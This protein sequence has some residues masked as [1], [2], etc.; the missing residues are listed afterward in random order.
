M[1]GQDSETILFTLLPLSIVG[2]IQA[3]ILLDTL[4]VFV[5]LGPQPVVLFTSISVSSLSM[6]KVVLEK[7]LVEILVIVIVKS[8]VT[9]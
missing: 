7:A 1:R 8:T 4:A 6:E 5:A 3:K 9:L 2:L